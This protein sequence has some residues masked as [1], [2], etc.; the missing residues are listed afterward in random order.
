MVSKKNTLN[1]IK[2]L[3]IKCGSTKDGAW[4]KCRQCKH[5]P[6]KD[7]DDM[8]QH[9]ILTHHFLSQDKL[10]VSAQQI[11]DGH[12]IE[13]R[14]EE[15]Q[16]VRKIVEDKELK[17]LSSLK[18]SRNVILSCVTFVLLIILAYVYR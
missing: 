8:S 2:A 12:P 16:M 5:N 15:L 7:F 1:M 4:K 6:Q 11:K 9:L 10:E 13:F 3:C 17:R 18:W 14:D